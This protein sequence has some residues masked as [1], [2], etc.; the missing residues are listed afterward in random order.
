M[1]RRYKLEEDELRAKR[2]FTKIA[3]ASKTVFSYKQKIKKTKT[4]TKKPDHKRSKEVMVKITGNSKNLD[5]V[6]RHIEYITRDYELPLFDD[7][8]N[9][10]KGQE[11]IND[12]VK[13][14]NFDGVIPEYEDSLKKE[15][16]EVI[17]FVFSMKHHHTTPADKLMRAVVK[18]V[19]EKYPNNLAHFAFHGDTDNPHIHCDLRIE[20]INRKRVDIKIEDLLNLRID[21]SKNLNKLGIEASA[22][23]RYEKY[24]LDKNIANANEKSIKNHHYEVVEFRNAKYKFDESAKDS[25]FV[26]YKS[27]RGDIVDIWSEDLQRVVKENDIKV[28]EFVRFKIVDKTPVTVKAKRFNKKTN[29][30]T[31]YTKQSLKNVWDCSVAGRLEKDLKTVKNDDIKKVTYSSEEITDVPE[32]HNSIDFAQKEKEF[33]KILKEKREKESLFG[34]KSSSKKTNKFIKPVK[35]EEKEI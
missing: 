29:K 3:N 24:N 20:D 13:L 22:T 15:R 18:T 6:K 8:G 16:R 31:V 32:N 30:W 27:N 14:F 25:F 17:H 10:Y 4:Y 5:A 28:G 11:D 1:A 2:V 23:R 12:Y 19:K 9:I 35:K 7:K 34:M 21:F 33:A 26:K